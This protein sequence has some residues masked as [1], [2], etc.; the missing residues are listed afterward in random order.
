MVEI[1]CTMEERFPA[2]VETVWNLVTDLD[3]W[4]DPELFHSPEL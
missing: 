3:H 1:I 4:Q 2:P